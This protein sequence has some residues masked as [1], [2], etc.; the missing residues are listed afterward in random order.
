MTMLAAV[1]YGPRDLRVEQL[2]VPEPGAGE[3]R[4]RI[5]AASTCGTDVKVWRRGYHQNMIRPPAVL[6]HECA[7]VI[8]AVG[9]G[10]AGWSP[11]TPVVAANSAPCTRC[12]YCAKR[13]YSQC[14]TLTY[15]NGAYAEYVIVPESIVRMNL[16]PL[17][18]G[19]DP[20]FATLTE[21]L[22]CVV[23]GLQRCPVASGD[24][25]V[26]LGSGPIGLFF[27]RLCV[28]AGATVTAL[29]RN[30]G[31]L[32]TATRLGAT[33]V[34][35]G[36][37]SDTG[38]QQQARATANGGRGFDVVI[39]CIGVPAAWNA[40]VTLAR[41]RGLVHL[42]G[43]CPRD[44][45]VELATE[46]IHYDELSITGTYHHTPEAIRE[47]LDLIA[48]GRIVPSEFL[49]GSIGIDDLPKALADLS[50]GAPFI[51]LSVLPPNA[52]L[53]GG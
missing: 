13:L 10:A 53:S 27:V 29:G 32:E 22:A 44:S 25:V 2:P 48:T 16:L 23:H 52:R 33:R 40:A 51:K 9:A 47:A 4:L 28:L 41:R 17:P 46:R 26:V 15:M 12:Y 34:I 6:G 14:E 50:E 8:D 21:P 24:E 20:R 42:F 36:D 19:L 45:S 39:E 43:G 11:G 37:A 38:L 18:I 30:A 5:A 31:R 3:V 35:E 7:G 49:S 1:L